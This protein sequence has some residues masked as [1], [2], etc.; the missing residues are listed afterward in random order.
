MA[1]FE[2]LL[3][4]SDKDARYNFDENS[5][6][7]KSFTFEKRIEIFD[8][9][10]VFKLQKVTCNPVELICRELLSPLAAVLEAQTRRIRQLRAR[11]EQ[12]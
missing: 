1:L 2:S 5:H 12:T 10:W 9:K 7:G 8:F 11:L 3:T 4:A 6:E